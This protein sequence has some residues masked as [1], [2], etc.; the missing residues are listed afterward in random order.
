MAWQSHVFRSIIQMPKRMDL[1]TD[2]E[3]ILQDWE[4]DKREEHALAFTKAHTAE[5]EE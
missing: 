1:W 3:A 2:W 4:D 5:M